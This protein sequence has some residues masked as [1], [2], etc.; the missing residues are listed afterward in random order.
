MSRRFHTFL[1]LVRQGNYLDLMEA[2]LSLLKKFGIVIQISN[3]FSC[4]NDR[5]LPEI[6]FTGFHVRS[7]EKDDLEPIAKFAGKDLTIYRERI[8]LFEDECREMNFRGELV[9]YCWL[10]RKE[11]RVPELD[12]KRALKAGEVYLYD[13]MIREDMRNR[14]FFGIFL[15]GL[16]REVI[17][18]Q[19]SFIIS[20]DFTNY[21]SRGTYTKLGFIKIGTR[22]LVRLWGLVVFRHES[23][24]LKK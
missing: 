16:I 17:A 2:F 21:K 4:D 22:M 5:S 15:I 1:R 19:G 3:F 23:S 14:G 10:S 18:R 20:I 7:L 24:A 12:F 6:R 13:G 8:E 9:G 11:M